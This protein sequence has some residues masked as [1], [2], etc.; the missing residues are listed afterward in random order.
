MTFAR[1][2]PVV[3]IAVGWVVLLA[4]SMLSCEAFAIRRVSMKPIATATELHLKR[5]VSERFSFGKRSN[6]SE[7]VEYRTDNGEK[8]V[9]H[10]RTVHFE[11]NSEKTHE[12][13]DQMTTEKTSYRTRNNFLG[14]DNR[15]AR[16]VDP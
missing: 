14:R 8:E 1:S 3:F 7:N 13:N 11:L 12:K 6:K 16:S 10:L 5:T 9:Y 2:C 15:F 4:P